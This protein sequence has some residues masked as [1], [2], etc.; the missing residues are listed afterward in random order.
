M[1]GFIRVT[2]R[3][4]IRECRRNRRSTACHR[5]RHPNVMS[6][7][8][9]S[10]I[11]NWTYARDFRPPGPHV[12]AEPGLKP[13]GPYP[14]RVRL[15]GAGTQGQAW[16][17]RLVDAVMKGPDWNRTATFLAWDD[18]GGFDDHVRPPRVDPVLLPPRPR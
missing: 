17:T 14:A 6:Y 10:Q 9:G 7:H 16:V 1:D 5:L 11:P 3:R 2:D 13:A 8:D 12:R 15:K 18:W 4:I